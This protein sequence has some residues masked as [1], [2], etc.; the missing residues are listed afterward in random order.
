MRHHRLLR[1]CWYSL[2]THLTGNSSH[3]STFQ[4]GFQGLIK[5]RAWIHYTPSLLSACQDHHPISRVIRTLAHLP[6]YEFIP[7]ESCHVTGCR[8]IVS[9]RVHWIWWTHKWSV[10]STGFWLHFNEMSP[11]DKSQIITTALRLV[12][13]YSHFRYVPSA[14]Q[15]PPR[16]D[17]GEFSFRYFPSLLRKYRACPDHPDVAP[18]HWT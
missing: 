10:M 11:K 18:C 13:S 4:T 9:N 14:N 12:C 8:L 1:S 5:L 6:K 3:L 16:A 15:A 7:I 2:L 17:S